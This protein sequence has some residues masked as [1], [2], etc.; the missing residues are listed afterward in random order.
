MTM[1]KIASGFTL[2]EM[3][4]VVVIVGIVMAVAIPA[5]QTHTLKA[6][7]AD[8]YAALDEIMKAQERFA[9]ENG[10]YTTDLTALGYTATQPSGRGLY[11]ITAAACAGSTIARCVILQAAAQGTQV[12]DKNNTAGTANTAITLNSRGARSGW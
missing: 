10:T 9:Y 12:E 3:L 2:I 5:Y 7:R 4:I 6:N 8:A 1:K 11:N